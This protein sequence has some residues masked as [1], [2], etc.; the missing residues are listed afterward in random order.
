M[1]EHNLSA[2]DYASE[3]GATV[4]ALTMPD[5]PSPRICFDNGFLL[6]TIPGW[7]KPMTLPHDEKKAMLASRE[8]RAAL[9]EASGGDTG[10]VGIANWPIYVINET[11]APENKQ[12]EGRSVKD[13]AREQGKEP[14]DAL[15]DIVVADDLMTGFGFPRGPERIEDWESRVKIW[16]DR[17]TVVG[18]S[19]AGAHL[20]F[21][22]TFNYSTAM[23]G[24]AVRER[25]L[26][27]IEEAIHMLTEV[28]ARLYGIRE[29]GRIADGW[30]ADIVVIDPETV[31]PQE[32]RMRFDLPTNA[33]RLFGGADGIDRVLVNG[34]EIVDHGEFTDARP[35][36]L[37]RSG[38]DT[39]TVTASA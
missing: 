6:D 7:Q 12:Y 18:A 37:F 8:G 29:R 20:D 32:V 30:H 3:R 16:R 28:P 34:T 17:R 1:A 24:K 14:L 22:A 36:T 27:P 25:G 2:S 31:G 13:I 11:F 9:V 19:D 38:R 10:L 15:L 33:P 4:L 39:D 26:M 35:G 23:L 5:A 21:L